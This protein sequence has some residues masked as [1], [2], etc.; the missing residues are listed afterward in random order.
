[1]ERNTGTPKIQVKNL[2]MRFGDL[3]VLND[4]N[5]TVNEGEF[6]SIVGPTG[7]GKTTFLN[8]TEIVIGTTDEYGNITVTTTVNKGKAD[9]ET[10]ILPFD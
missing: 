8:E 7:C 5:F 2:T 3:T 6:V 4:I 9:D 1:M 10:P